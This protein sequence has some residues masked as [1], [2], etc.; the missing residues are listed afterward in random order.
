M[1][2]LLTEKSL[3]IYGTNKGYVT[4]IA[5]AVTHLLKPLSE[6]FII[7]KIFTAIQDYDNNDNKIETSKK[8]SM[9]GHSTCI[10]ITIKP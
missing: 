3:I 4:A 2:L 7:Q 10:A 5:V 8:K 9:K 1:H 6:E